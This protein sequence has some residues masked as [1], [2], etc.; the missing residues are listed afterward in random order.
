M[1]KDYLNKDCAK[2]GPW[3]SYLSISNSSKCIYPHFRGQRQGI[4]LHTLLFWCIT[5][6]RFFHFRIKPPMH[7]KTQERTKYQNVSAV[8]KER[9]I[10]YVYGLALISKLVRSWHWTCNIE[11]TEWFVIIYLLYMEG[12]ISFFLLSYSTNMHCQ[13]RTPCNICKLGHE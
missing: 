4:A 8:T 7:F 9:K 10:I 5:F 11:R 3:F 1:S 6:P 13:I 2:S 12:I